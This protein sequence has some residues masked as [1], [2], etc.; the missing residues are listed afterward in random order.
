[1]LKKLYINNFATV[2][3]LTLE[4]G[5][6]LNILS[7][8][9]G[10]GKSIIIESV[11]FLFGKAK[12]VGN[13]IRTGEKEAFIGCVFDT[14][15]EEKYKI[16]NAILE[17]CGIGTNDDEVL[18]KRTVNLSGKSKYFINN[19][20]A[21][22]TVVEKLSEILVNIF[23]QNDKRFLISND[24]QLAFLD[25]YAGNQTF[26]SDIK[27]L[28]KEINGIKYQLDELYKK[29]EDISKIKTINSYIISDAERLEISSEEDEE[30]IK[31]ELTRLENIN[32]I[33]ETIFTASDLIENE[34]TGILKNFNLLISLFEKLEIIDPQFKKDNNLKNAFEAKLLTEDI[35]SSLEKRSSFD[36]DEERLN[37]LRNKLDLIITIE[38]KY[39]FKNIKEFLDGYQKA[40]NEICDANIID[41][42]I[43]ESKNKLEEKK[44]EYFNI[45]KI[46]LKNRIEASKK[47]EKEII[48]ELYFLGMK[49][50]FNINIEHLNFDDGYSETGLAKTVF[51]FSANP[52]EEPKPL[53]MIASGGELSRV[54]L[55]MLKAVNSKKNAGCLIF[56][57][58]DSGIGGEVGDFIGEALRKIS[59]NSQ[60]ICITHLAQVA[61]CG[62]KHLLVYK[63]VKDGRTYTLLKDLNANE[64][65]FEIA[66]M[67]SGDTESEASL[68]HAKEILKKRGFVG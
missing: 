26:I 64:R 48:E 60:V 33:K 21:N 37:T 11:N 14:G 31:D 42:K 20:P 23:G 13:I 59:E 8:E 24:S 58:I 62:Q 30:N 32:K 39:G 25:E 28:Y 43:A 65:I 5:Q 49:P 3:S 12:N 35:S 66:R 34:E 47:L 16:I 40:K 7:G 52:G 17:E 53:S 63:T 10:A 4:F 19:E 68:A 45:D 44:N 29:A 18:I 54:S 27:E 36:Y 22:K 67:L 2:D 38:N 41:E 1:M 51:M 46:L 57:E 9:T 15:R 55:C 56:D 6:N 50:V 61:S